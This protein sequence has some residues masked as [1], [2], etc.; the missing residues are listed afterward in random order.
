MK[1]FRPKYWLHLLNFHPTDADNMGHSKCSHIHPIN[2]KNICTKV[3]SGHPAS[4]PA[5]VDFAHMITKNLS[6][7]VS[8]DDVLII[9]HYF[10]II[11]S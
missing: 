1:N 9:S 5:L 3:L 2:I 4:R 10:L 6:L 8:P 11:F 7:L